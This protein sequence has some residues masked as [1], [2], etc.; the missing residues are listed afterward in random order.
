MSN[1]VAVRQ[2]RTTFGFA[3][4]D[5]YPSYGSQHAS[6]QAKPSNGSPDINDSS[7]KSSWFPRAHIIPV[8]LLEPRDVLQS[9]RTFLSFIRFALSLFFTSIGMVIGFHLDSGP[10]SNNDNGNDNGNSDEP[11]VRSSLF[12]HTVSIVL[13]FLAFA[14]LLVAGVNY[15]RTVRRYSMKK[16]KT[17]STNNTI[18][19]VCI[20]SVIVTLACLNISLIVERYLKDQ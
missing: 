9:E 10:D 1:R 12:N 18:M 5:L 2:N 16:I 17:H 13:I 4:Q 3:S 7:S 11:P 19:V 14:T 8:V 20:T 6:L 15:F